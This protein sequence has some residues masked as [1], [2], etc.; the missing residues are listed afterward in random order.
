MGSEQKLRIINNDT[1]G[2]LSPAKRQRYEDGVWVAVE[3]NIV[4][5]RLLASDTAKFSF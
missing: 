1:V 3:A 2:R 4:H 5:R